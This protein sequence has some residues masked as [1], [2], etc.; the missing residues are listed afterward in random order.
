ML[1]SIKKSLTLG[2]FSCS[3]KVRFLPYFNFFLN[4]MDVFVALSFTEALKMLLISVFFTTLPNTIDCVNNT[5]LEN[6]SSAFRFSSTR[7]NTCRCY[8]IVEP[9]TFL[10]ITVCIY[11]CRFMPVGAFL[12]KKY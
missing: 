1:L 11:H 12:F 8:R 6:S 9:I 7:L 10:S 3:P 5:F 4:A 2:M